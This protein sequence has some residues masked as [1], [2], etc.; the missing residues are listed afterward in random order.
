MPAKSRQMKVSKYLSRHLRHDPGRLGLTLE[1]GGWISVEL[2]LQACAQRSFH[3]TET[4]LR[5]VV[6][7]ND[8]R[9][10]S[11]DSTGRRIRANQGHSIEVDL[12]LESVQ[13]PEI[14]YHGTAQRSLSA[15]M[16][17]GLDRRGRHHVHLSADRATAD[18]VGRRHGQPVIL[19]VAA[20][21]MAADG[22]DFFVTENGVWLVLQ[23]P[24]KYLAT[25]N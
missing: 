3:L 20:G 15:I 7:N 1:P 25:T 11:F 19:E 8:K 24:V 12:G 5:Q 14:L 13:P 22:F 21:E 10:F 2:L 18:R 17:T 4:E 9:R 23:V 6:Q 16:E